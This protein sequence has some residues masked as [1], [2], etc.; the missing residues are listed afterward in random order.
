MLIFLLLIIVSSIL[1]RLV[2]AEEITISGNGSQTVNQAS[3]SS[4]NQ[5][6]VSQTNQATV[7]NN[8]TA[9]ANTGG[10]SANSN[11][12]DQTTIETGNV[13]VDT[14]IKNS[15]NQSSVDLTCCPT[16]ENKAVISNNSGL[17]QNS[18]ATSHPNNNNVVVIQEATVDNNLNVVANTGSNQADFN[19]NKVKILTGNISIKTDIDNSSINSSSIKAP[20]ADPDLNLIAK[21]IDNSY[22]SK[23]QIDI[24]SNN[25]MLTYINDLADITNNQNIIA[26]SGN[27]DAD[28]NSGDVVIKSGDVTIISSIENEPIDSSIVSFSCCTSPNQRQTQPPAS[29]P[30]G[31]SSTGVSSGSN[32][33]SG[34]GSGGSGGGEVLGSSSNGQV[35]PATGSLWTIILTMISA[36][37]FSLGLYLRL[38]PGQDPGNKSI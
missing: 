25:S 15:V 30:G 14:S 23:N 33:N 34:G 24:N 12:G 7:T 11:S 28:F 19:S 1:P 38:H 36:I 20:F 26:N 21:I 35:L 6:T 5:V 9:N 3:V 4:D 31:G 32:G 37:M 22:Q 17:S 16:S 10:N 13:N 27:N 8:I 18:I 29:Q 2:S